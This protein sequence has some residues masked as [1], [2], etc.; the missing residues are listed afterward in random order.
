MHTY[1]D[2]V[3]PKCNPYIQQHLYFSFRDS[4]TTYNEIHIKW[5]KGICRCAWITTLAVSSAALLQHFP[6]HDTCNNESL[7]HSWNTSQC[8][9]TGQGSPGQQQGSWREKQWTGRCHQTGTSQEYRIRTHS[10]LK[11]YTHLMLVF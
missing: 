4:N 1:N 3:T 8:L 2:R 7:K 10:S 6:A 11:K 9:C 5:E